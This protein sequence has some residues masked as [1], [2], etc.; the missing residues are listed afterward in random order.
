MFVEVTLIVE[1][2]EEVPVAPRDAVTE[3]GGRKVIFVL[4]GQRVERRSVV[5]GLGD[6][7]IIEVRQGVEP[8]ERIVVRGLETLT[9]NQRVNVSGS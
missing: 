7:D 3:R 5:L 8:G 4:K 6:D 2:R 1:R 9:D